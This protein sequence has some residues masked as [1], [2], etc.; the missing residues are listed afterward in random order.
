MESPQPPAPF[1]PPFLKTTGVH[2]EGAFQPD[3][4]D[5]PRDTK[6]N[7]RPFTASSSSDTLFVCVHYAHH[8]E[9]LAAAP[10][11]A[12]I[13]CR[14]GRVLETSNM[15][16][17]W[18]SPH[19]EKH[20]YSMAYTHFASTRVVDCSFNPVFN[21]LLVVSIPPRAMQEKDGGWGIRLDLV[22][23][24]SATP[25]EDTLAAFAALPLEAVRPDTE[26]SMTVEFPHQ[27]QT[28]PDQAQIFVT[29]FRQ[30]RDAT[31][32]PQWN[33]L[34]LTV[35]AVPAIHSSF[36][37]EQTIAVVQLLPTSTKTIPLLVESP[38]PF[39]TVRCHTDLVQAYESTNHYRVTP[40]GYVDDSMFAWRYPTLFDFSSA[41][42]AF[43]FHISLYA[44]KATPSYVC[45]GSSSVTTFAVPTRQGSKVPWP[46][47][48]IRMSD[49]PWEVP[50]HGMLRWWEGASWHD[51]RKE[52][53]VCT[54][55]LHANNHTRPVPQWMAAIA[56]GLNRHPISTV[57]DT[58]GIVGVIAAMYHSRDVDGQDSASTLP[59]AANDEPVKTLDAKWHAQL[60][61]LVEDIASKQAFIDKMQKE[62]DKRTTAIKSCGVEIVDLRKHLQKKD[63]LIQ[64]LQVKLHNYEALEQRQQEEIRICLDGNGASATSFPVLAQHHTKLQS[65]HNALEA[66]HAELSKKLLEA[67][68]F[69][70]E[71]IEAKMQ[72][73]TLEAAHLAQANFIQKANAEMQKLTV[74]KQTIA[75]QETVIAKL[76]KLVESKLAEAKASA[77]GPNVHAE[78]FR[79]RL[80]NSYLKEQLT[81]V[82][83][84]ELHA[85]NSRSITRLRAATALQDDSHPPHKGRIEPLVPPLSTST[86]KPSMSSRALQPLPI[87]PRRTTSPEETDR[88]MVAPRRHQPPN[89]STHDTQ[90]TSRFVVHKPDNKPALDVSTN[91]DAV[92]VPSPDEDKSYNEDVLWV[93]IRVLEDQLRVNTTAAAQEIATLKARVFELEVEADASR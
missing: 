1:I 10:P 74:Y 93:K 83:A 43:C 16:E 50:L 66:S 35:D 14:V 59:L 27:Q 73:K 23:R 72:Y 63:Q 24:P 15:S 71:L 88:D 44:P 13:V 36:K 53:V 26:V 54:N 77:V 65:K 30:R 21:E 45:V 90:T 55:R 87:N 6:P 46:S 62:M 40:G 84:T 41:P 81:Y 17:F 11:T 80:E 67:R 70:A 61:R 48:L 19:G 51:F 3:F 34:E 5:T 39:L 86:T 9:A 52:R 91:T 37:P 22:Q 33:R 56:R 20:A 60:Q 92:A 76:E 25:G 58:G 32:S 8:L 64:S 12:F 2:D 38:L 75:T 4:C 18:A 29:L 89:Q 47:I 82:S 68:N 79:L 49:A 7:A 78:I 42:T 28:C 57:V 85:S 31:M 69:E